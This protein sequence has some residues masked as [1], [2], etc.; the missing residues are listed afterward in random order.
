MQDSGVLVDFVGRF[1]NAAQD[2]DGV[3]GEAAIVREVLAYV[4]WRWLLCHPSGSMSTAVWG[5]M[6]RGKETYS[7]P[8]HITIT[9]RMRPIEHLLCELDRYRISLQIF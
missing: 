8:A 6:K 9:A 1:F 7:I 4:L 3:A 2:V 5:G